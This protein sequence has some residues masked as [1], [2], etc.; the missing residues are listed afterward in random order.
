MGRKIIAVILFLYALWQVVT[1]FSMMGG[2]Y[3]SSQATAHLLWAFL[4]VIGGLY[5]FKKKK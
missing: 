5:L 1:F 3:R 4:A 2:D